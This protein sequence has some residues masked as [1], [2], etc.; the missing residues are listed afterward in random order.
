MIDR[1]VVQV[2]KGRSTLRGTSKCWITG[3]LLAFLYLISSPISAQNPAIP[4]FIRGD[5]NGD[6]RHDLSDPVLLL[7]ELFGANSG[8]PCAMSADVNADGNLLLDDVI[9]LLGLIFTGSPTSLPA[10]YPECGQVYSQGSLDCTSPPCSLGE[11]TEER[12]WTMPTHRQGLL[13]SATFTPERNP[14]IRWQTG[15]GSGLIRE[16]VPFVEYGLIAGEL[17]PG[18]LIL[19]SSTGW[20]SGSEVPT[21]LHTFQ[22]FAIDSFGEVVLFHCRLA[23]FDESESEIAPPANLNLPGPHTVSVFETFF[24][25]THPLPWP[26]PYPLWNCNSS[27]P[28]VA[29]VTELK[30]LRILIPN[31]LAETAPVLIFHHGT[32]FSW[33]DYDGIL[34][35]LATHGIICVSVGNAFS[36]DVYPDW[37]CWGGHDDAAALIHRTREVVEETANIQGSPLFNRVDASRIFYS[38]HSRGAS[39]AITA[40]E[41]DSNIRGLILL[42]PTDAKQDSWIGNTNRWHDLP[43]IPLISITAEQDTDVIYPYAERL[44]ER[45]SGS[46]TS[47]CILGGCHGFSSDSSN[48]GCGSCDWVP[49]SPDVDSCPYIS[50]SLQRDLSRKWMLAFLKRH[51][52]D[53]LSLEGFL[54]GGSDEIQNLESVASKRNLSGKIMLDDFSNFPTNLRGYQI[55]ETNMIMFESGPCYDWPFPLPQ[56][57]PEISNL[58][59]I[60]P[61]Q[62]TATINMP[63]GFIF[64]PLAAGSR[65]NLR[66]RIK[67]H[68]VHGGLDNMGWF[69]EATLTLTDNAARSASLNLRD[70]LPAN[71]N[72]PNTTGNSSVIPLKQQRFID[73]V[74]PLADFLAQQADLD[75]QSLGMLDWVFSTDGSAPFDVRFGIDDLRLE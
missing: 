15:N 21:G 30:P 54:Y 18:D 36:F 55:S 57:F 22:A 53:D 73:V 62:G 42:Q 70:Y 32:G 61:A 58:I 25:H 64:D 28:P 45:M 6:Q 66:F 2:A 43:D 50:R 65:R 37:Y 52:F 16:R 8:L 56:P 13:Y 31:N 63:L 72:H 51:A 26:P 9:T 20:V 39:A 14:E 24:D 68:D 11:I 59:C 17:L 5:I 35:F 34:G 33:E 44:L 19:D 23:S 49:I 4:G 7:E 60:L 48:L 1:S 38:G 47:I 12:Q 74:I 3:V 69:F 29:Q 41:M 10:P 75:L 71:G 67:N 27:P 46:A 40:S